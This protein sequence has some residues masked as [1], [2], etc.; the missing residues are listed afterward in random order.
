MAMEQ[1]RAVGCQNFDH[2]SFTLYKD[3]KISLDQALANA[4]SGSNLC[5]KIKLVGLKVD[6]EAKE[7]E[8]VEPVPAA[9]G[10]T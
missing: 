4:D 9:L 1:G 6:D 2:R 10:K 3:A 8:A 7:F 5:R